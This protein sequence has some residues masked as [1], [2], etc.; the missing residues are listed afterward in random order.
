MIANFIKFLISI[1]TAILPWVSGGIFQNVLSSDEK[2]VYQLAAH[3]MNCG[4]SYWSVTPAIEK[5]LFSG[6]VAL[7]CDIQGISGGGLVELRRHLIDQTLRTA[8]SLHEGPIMRNFEGLPSNAYDETITIGHENEKYE[9][10]GQTDIATNGF[11]RLRSSFASTEIPTRGNL[12]SLKNFVGGVEVRTTD[13]PGW[14]HV[15]MSYASHVVKPWYASS[16]MFK[17]ELVTKSQS[18]LE[19]RKEKVL[20]DLAAHL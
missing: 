3:Q 5:N 11:T 6:T 18:S 20:G 8:T 16:E 17:N 4:P 13:R 15:K 14:Y 10:R 9:I 19:E 7:E 1:L 12:R 2:P